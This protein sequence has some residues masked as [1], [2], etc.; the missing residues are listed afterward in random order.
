[1][2]ERK[3]AKSERSTYE[4]I[5]FRMFVLDTFFGIGM[6]GNRVQF[7]KHHSA[8]QFH[9]CRSSVLSAQLG[10]VLT[11]FKFECTPPV[12]CALLS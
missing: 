10:A 12:I 8:S 7:G 2:D 11:V 5:E 4:N 6:G 3:K 1:M 9:T